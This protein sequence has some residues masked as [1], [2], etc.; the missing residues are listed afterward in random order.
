MSNFFNDRLKSEKFVLLAARRAKTY[1]FRLGL[2]LFLLTLIIGLSDPT[3]AA[4]DKTIGLAYTSIDGA[5]ALQAA[6]KEGYFAEEGLI[7][8]PIAADPPSF[9][10]LIEEKRVVGGELN[11][12]ALVFASQGVPVVISAG[13]FSGFLE[14]IGLPLTKGQIVLVTVDP[15]S[16]PAVAAA[17]RLKSQGIDPIKDVKWASAPENELVS[18][19]TS[20]KAT[21]LARWNLAAKDPSP[22]AGQITAHSG[23]PEKAAEIPLK[24][25]NHASKGPG[26]HSEE[27]AAKG[28][29]KAPSAAVSPSHQPS[30]VAG[31]D[32]FEVI[33][34]AR[35]SLP[36]APHG[37][38]HSAANP[39]AHHTAEHHFFESFVVLDSRFVKE[40][41]ETATA[42]T[43]A[44]I[45][46][47]RWTGENKEKAAQLAVD[48]KLWSGEVSDLVGELGRYMWM[49]GV[50]QVKD[51]LK[52]YIHEG[53]G[54]GSLP[55]NTDEK[56]FFEKIFVQLLPD[57]S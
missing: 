36:K 30:P 54:R 41:P 24:G 4:A 44:L 50:N 35:A 31:L 16:G 51:H 29:S 46:G 8:Q 20:G 22:P 23:H 19:L 47:A 28:H 56:A 13:L 17:R 6:I 26:S 57:L 39:H 49:P 45:R 32:G 14:I 2:G 53:I 27:K 5:I 12:T 25:A 33:F 10:T 1:L 9:K 3:L 21:A 7:V 18:F 43:R 15:I 42:I 40:D 48:Q 38:S 11:S 37:A 52:S 34:S 55:A